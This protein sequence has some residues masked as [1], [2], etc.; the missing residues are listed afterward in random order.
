MRVLISRGCK[1]LVFAVTSVSRVSWFRQFSEDFPQV[2]VSWFWTSAKSSVFENCSPKLSVLGGV[3]IARNCD[4]YFWGVANGFRAF[5]NMHPNTLF[6]YSSPF[7]MV[8]WGEFGG[9][10]LYVAFCPRRVSG[11]W[12]HLMLRNGSNNR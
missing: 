8:G 7:P 10:S 1:C 2:V 6:V 4:I 12:L 11:N 9:Q 3:K 5:G